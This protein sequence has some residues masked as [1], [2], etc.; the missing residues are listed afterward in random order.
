MFGG[1][2]RKIVSNILILVLIFTFSPKM[3][4]YAADPVVG[5]SYGGG[6]VAYI[7][8]EGDPG[9]DAGLVQGLIAATSDQSAGIQWYNGSNIETLAVDTALGSGQNNTSEI[10]DIQ[11][12][13]SYAAQICNDL[14]EGG[15]GDWYLPSQDELNKLYLNKDTIGGFSSSGYWSSSELDISQAWGQNFADGVQIPPVPKS[16]S[17]NVRAV[18]SFSVEAEA[19]DPTV[20]IEAIDDSGSED[21]DGITFRV[22][23]T[24]GTDSS[25]LVNFSVSGSATRGGDY[26]LSEPDSIV[27]FSEEDSYRDIG[28]SGCLDDEL[29]ED[30][31]TI[32]ITLEDGDGYIVGTPSSDT[33]ML[34]DTDGSSAASI[35]EIPDDNLEACIRDALG[36]PSGSI[37]EEDAL[38]LTNLFCMSS[39]VFDLTGLEYFTNLNT[40]FLDENDIEDLSPLGELVSLVT[41]DVERNELVDISLL[42]NL[43]N[44][45]SLDLNHNSIIDIS[46]LSGM[47]NLY[48]LNLSHNSI[49]DIS[50]LSAITSLQSLHADHNE[51]DIVGDLSGLTSLTTLWLNNNEIGN[52]LGFIN[53]LISLE[54]LYLGDNSITDISELSG[55]LDSTEL[56]EL[57]L[58]ETELV[59]VDDPTNDNNIT[60]IT[61]LSGLTGL[62]YL[63]LCGNEVTSVAPL[64]G[65]TLMENLDLDDALI[66]DVS[67]LYGMTNLSDLK[68]MGVPITDMSFLSHFPNLTSFYFYGDGEVITGLDTL[69]SLNYLTELMLSEAGISDLSFLENM[70]SLIVLNLNDNSI[71]DIES[72]QYLTELTSLDLSDNSIVDIQSLVDNEGIGDGDTVVLSYNPLSNES[73]TLIDELNERGVNVVNEEDEEDW[74]TAWVS[75]EEG[76]TTVY[77]LNSNHLTGNLPEGDLSP[78]FSIEGRDGTALTAGLQTE[79]IEYEGTTYSDQ[80]IVLTFEDLVLPEYVVVLEG[81]ITEYIPVEYYG[82]AVCTSFTYTDWS[83][84]SCNNSTQSREVL[85]SSPD[86]CTGGTPVLS[87]SCTPSGCGGVLILNVTPPLNN[88]PPGRRDID[89]SDEDEDEEE[90]ND[91]EVE[92]D[93]E[94]EN[95]VE[96]DREENR[97]N[98]DNINNN[99]QPRRQIEPE[100]KNETETVSE[101]RSVDIDFETAEEVLSSVESVRKLDTSV[102]ENLLRTTVDS[103]RIH[104]DSNYE[105]NVLNFVTAISDKNE[106]VDKDKDSV[107]DYMEI[108]YGVESESSEEVAEKVVF[109]VDQKDTNVPLIVNL[110]GKKVGN[111]PLILAVYKPNINLNVFVK[112][113]D[114]HTNTNND[115]YFQIGTIGV[116]ENGRGQLQIALD[117]GLSAGKYMAKLVGVDKVAG[118]EVSF[119]VTDVDMD[120]YGLTVQEVQIQ[121]V[122]ELDST[123]LYVIDGLEVALGNEV[124]NSEEFIASKQE[125]LKYIVKGNI[126][127]SDPA[128]KIVYL[129]YKSTIFSS[130]TLSD[131]AEEVEYFQIEVPTKVAKNEMHNLSAY[132]YSPKNNTSSS[133]KSYQFIMK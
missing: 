11:G 81:E 29:V 126:K 21:G 116:D 33:A 71:V 27:E 12:L 32:I 61:I 53:G 99:E 130:V 93:Q 20:T 15:Y 46:Y 72:L 52:D 75:D 110:D 73:L 4:V 22:S 82:G 105:S 127:S 42:S 62:T 106:D 113:L 104:S 40:L 41:L 55:L 87:Q 65:M 59:D 133:A 119:E 114:D 63:S 91:E 78:Y 94:E 36:I 7:L 10:V 17:M 102:V 67:P 118:P 44:L 8:Q 123:V 9:Y 77:L 76:S 96:E 112:N 60:D 23:R 58:G 90:E 39:G 56:T 85:T 129:T 108:I 5:D 64:T 45:Q 43:I 31:E 124:F 47:T 88:N 79:D 103:K 80:V 86:G 26:C 37:T 101:E 30:P 6:I 48:S 121:D 83:I 34:Y 3:S 2:F 1:K 14:V 89:L 109:K 68:M 115:G 122:P 50:D 120:I 128:R 70:P 111:S 84:C 125:M 16:L 74:I 24:G 98:E 13:G 19:E 132:S 66:S 18:R 28:F 69:S 97:I 117:K 92:E 107:P 35:I 54:Q 51:I 38:G 100:I 49:T 57:E 95:I 25:L 131:A